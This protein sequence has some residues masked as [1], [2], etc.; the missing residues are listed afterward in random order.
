MIST[1]ADFGPVA[2]IREDAAVEDAEQAPASPAKTPA[3]T[4]AAS[5]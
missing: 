4:K 1:S 5:S 2:E 3:T